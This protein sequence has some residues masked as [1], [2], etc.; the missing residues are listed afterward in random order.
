[1]VLLKI[2][3]TVC[4][5]KFINHLLC[6]DNCVMTVHGEITDGCSYNTSCSEE[7]EEKLYLVNGTALLGELASINSHVHKLIHFLED[8][9]RDEESYGMKVA[10]VLSEMMGLHDHLADL[11]FDE[12]NMRHNLSMTNGEIDRAKYL[13]YDSINCIYNFNKLLGG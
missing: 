4:I 10:H 13:Y 5:L 6:N 12:A 3:N 7:E 9:Q 8:K 11:Q 1:M 2:I